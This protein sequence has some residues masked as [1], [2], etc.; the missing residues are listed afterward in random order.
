MS[1]ILGFRKQV[2]KLYARFSLQVTIILRFILGLIVFQLINSN[3]G[4]MEQFSTPIVSFGLAA[5]LAFFPLMMMALAASV[6]IILHFYALAM[7]VMAVTLLIFIILYCVYFRF[8]PGKS[9]LILLVPLAFQFQVPFVIPIAFGLMG[10]PVMILPIISGTFVYNLLYYVKTTDAVYY[11]EDVQGMVD[12]VV[13]FTTAIFYNQEMWMIAGILSLVLL[14]VYAF[15][16]RSF[17]HSWKV[18]YI[19]G[20]FFAVLFLV[21]GDYVFE[22]EMSLTAIVL[23]GVLAI[24][25]GLLL[26]LLF[27]RVDYSKT[28]YLQFSDNDYYYYVKAIPRYLVKEAQPD[29]SL[30]EMD[31]IDES[32]QDEERRLDQILERQSAQ[33]ETGG[34]DLGQTMVIDAAQAHQLAVAHQKSGDGNR[35]ARK[36]PPTNKPKGNQRPKASGNRPSG[37]L[38]D[39]P[40]D[41]SANSGKPRPKKQNRHPKQGKQ[42]ELLEGQTDNILLTRSLNE[43]LGLNKDNKR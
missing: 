3:L 21:A 4:F 39:R 28:E 11:A 24:F 6:L 12:V 33:F 31:E 10:A 19:V 42:A 43:E 17:N 25:V 36:R 29:G 7:P 9:W 40:S 1:V 20:A 30:E 38:G 26:E 37:K 16:T 8:T 35:Q 2:Q 14:I 32:W 23:D 34:E 5:V 22:L 15:R 18:A 41:R 27:L 13:D